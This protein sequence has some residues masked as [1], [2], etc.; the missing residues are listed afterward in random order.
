VAGSKQGR[1]R[2][3]FFPLFLETGERTMSIHD[4][5]AEITEWPDMPPI[6]NSDV[7]I[8]WLDDSLTAAL[9]RFL[10]ARA[11]APESPNASS[12]PSPSPYP[13]PVV[14]PP[15]AILTLSAARGRRCSRCC[16]LRHLHRHPVNDGHVFFL[17]I[18]DLQIFEANRSSFGA[19]DASQCE[20][21]PLR[22]R[23]TRRTRRECRRHPASFVIRV[24]YSLLLWHEDARSH[25]PLRRR[26]SLGW[27]H[28]GLGRAASAIWFEVLGVAS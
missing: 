16:I 28:Q 21:H 13:F 22:N 25:A 6:T 11:R 12:N 27:L 17:R 4:Q 15:T 2:L 26:L 1:G 10:Q 3:G 5:L 8:K 9:A 19:L 14:E 20:R 24:L 23:H 18:V 7:E